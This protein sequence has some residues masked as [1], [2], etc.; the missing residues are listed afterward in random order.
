MNILIAIDK[1]FENAVEKMWKENSKT[2]SLSENFLNFTLETKA[3]L[4][5]KPQG[6]AVI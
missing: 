5:L 6:S 1:P 2:L 3:Y 4:I